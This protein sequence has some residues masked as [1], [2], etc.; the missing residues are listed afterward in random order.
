MTINPIQNGDSGASVRAKLN[1]VIG[2]VNGLGTSAALDAGT[3]AGNLVQL[4]GQGRLPAVDGSQLTGITSGSGGTVTSVAA[5]GANG[6]TVTGGPITSSGTLAFAVDATAMRAHI[7][8]ADG[9]TAG[10]TWGADISGQPTLGNAAALDVGTTAG[11]VAAGDDGRLSDARE[12]TAE[13]VSHAEAEAGTATTRRAWNALRVRQAVVAWWGTVTA[14]A[15]R[16]KAELGTAA[17]SDTGDFAAAAHGHDA[18]TTAVAGFM[19]AADKEKLDG[20]ATGATANATDAHLLDRDNHTGE[21]AIS[22]VTGLQAALDARRVVVEHGADADTARPAG[23]VY[24]EWVGS[25]N[26]TNATAGDTW[27]DTSA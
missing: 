21:Q 15:L 6:I 16:A 11:T 13:T 27:L 3:S 7:N 24:V 2:E 25:V 26:P 8:V 22:T 10:A 14:A 17:Q 20:I 19:A 9:A 12:W 23:A 5:T 1:T 4:D 18:A